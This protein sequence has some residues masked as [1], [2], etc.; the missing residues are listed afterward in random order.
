[1]ETPSPRFAGRKN[2]LEFS[3]S[4]FNKVA[5]NDIFVRRK[6]LAFF[7]R[8]P[9]QIWPKD[10]SEQKSYDPDDA[11]EYEFHDPVF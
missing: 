6:I 9:D 4:F 5:R 3:G 7:C 8:I 1:M 10:R 11:A 2:S